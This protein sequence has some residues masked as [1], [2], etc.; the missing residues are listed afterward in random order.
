MPSGLWQ[1]AVG[2]TRGRV[3]AEGEAVVY[4]PGAEEGRDARELAGELLLEQQDWTRARQVV[5][6]E[7]SSEGGGQL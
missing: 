7:A 1:W 6:R 4:V 5:I 2:S 3:H